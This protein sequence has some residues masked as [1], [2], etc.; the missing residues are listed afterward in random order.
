MQ[1]IDKMKKIIFIFILLSISL[2]LFDKIENSR[3]YFINGPLGEVYYDLDENM[4][5]SE[6]SRPM[7]V[8]EDT[9]TGIFQD[10]GDIFFI[11]GGVEVLRIL[12]T[13]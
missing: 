9:D 5:L 6:I 1:G 8:F 12:L 3:T 2:Y 11:A 10:S 4:K 7:V 13:D